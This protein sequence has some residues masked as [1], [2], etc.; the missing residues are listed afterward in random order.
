MLGRCFP[1]SVNGDI[2]YIE[3]HCRHYVTPNAITLRAC[4]RKGVL[5]N[6]FR[7]PKHAPVARGLLPSSVVSIVVE[8][9]DWDR[10]RFCSLGRHVS[11]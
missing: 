9:S 6:G 11:G 2:L 7:D 1:A 3:A 8:I 4:E 5:K 10:A